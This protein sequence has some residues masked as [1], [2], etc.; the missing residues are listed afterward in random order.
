MAKRFAN[1]VEIQKGACNPTAIAGILH[2]AC[3]ECLDEGGVPR[4]DP[5]VRLIAHQ[6]HHILSIRDID[7]CLTTYG[8]LHAECEAQI[9]EAA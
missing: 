7:D 3:K 5:A 8:R 9:Q 6:L 4:T 1:A 2:E